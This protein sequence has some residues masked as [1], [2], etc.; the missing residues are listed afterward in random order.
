MLKYKLLK[1]MIS[2]KL[3]KR[4]FLSL[5]KFDDDNFVFLFINDTES[6]TYLRGT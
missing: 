5:L 6:R 3:L 2:Y 1:E 4:V